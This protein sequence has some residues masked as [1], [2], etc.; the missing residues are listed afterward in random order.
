VAPTGELNEFVILPDTITRDGQERPVLLSHDEV[1]RAFELYIHWLLDNNISSLPHKHYM[2]LDPNAPLLVDDNFKPFTKQSRG[3]SIS[4]NAINKC[5]DKLIKNTL[6]WDQGVRRLSLVRTY[7]IEAKKAGMSTN[8]IMI[9]SGF[10]E[11]SVSKILVMD[12]SAYSP[13]YDWFAKRRTQKLERTAAFIR[14]RE[15][16]M[17]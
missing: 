14:R 9:T 1:R 2:G 7:V 5:I 4:P 15:R 3:N 13:I 6:L 17:K 10:S 12:Y 8:D 16:F 11:D